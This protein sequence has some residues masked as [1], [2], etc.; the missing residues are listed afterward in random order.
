M[1][2]ED[3]GVE[4][5]GT[6]RVGPPDIEVGEVGED[7][8][9]GS[10]VALPFRDPLELGDI[11]G[12]ASSGTVIRTGADVASVSDHVPTEGGVPVASS[13]STRTGDNVGLILSSPPSRW[14]FGEIV[15]VK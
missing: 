6:R 5:V 10:T 9:V 14:W 8:V 11:V 1:T 13:P 4:V 7:S 12:T 3:G 2:G 15:G